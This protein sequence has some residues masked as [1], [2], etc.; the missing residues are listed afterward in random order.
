MT[1]EFA[2]MRPD[3]ARVIA[4]EWKYPPPYDFYDMTADPEDLQEF[5]IPSSWPTVIEAV[6]SDGE[7]VGFFTAEFAGDEAELGLGM[8]PDL[9]GHGSGA[10]FVRACIGRLRHLHP[11]RQRVILMVAAFNGRALR[12]YQRCGFTVTGS[13]SSVDAGNEVEFIDMELLGPGVR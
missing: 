10:E 7:L 12:V 6:T 4:E 11:H 1:L 13:H 9:T 3:Q 2:R 8:R 5:L